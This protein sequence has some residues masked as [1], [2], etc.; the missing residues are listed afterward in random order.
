MEASGGS[1]CGSQKG[2]ILGALNLQDLEEW[3][4][5]GQEQARKLLLK[6]K[7]LFAL[8]DLDLGDIPLIKHWIKLTDP[9]PFKDHYQCIYPHMYDHMKAHLQKMLDIGA[10]RKLHNQMTSVVVL[11]Q[12]K[13]GSL[14]FCIDLRKLNSWTIMDIYLLLHIYETLN[15]L[16]GLQWFSSLHPKSGYWQVKM[17]EESKPLTTF[18]MGPL[19]FYECHRMPFR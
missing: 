8:S 7:H 18:T 16:Q 11:V 15:S 13:D 6:W 9:M 19:G 5:A 12:K 1:A 14:W 10:I 4:E 17:D 2:W 3:P